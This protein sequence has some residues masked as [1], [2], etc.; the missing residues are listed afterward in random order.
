MRL[1]PAE[2]RM[3]IEELLSL[4]IFSKMNDVLKSRM[5][6]SKNEKYTLDN[7]ID[8]TE[9]KI[10][11]RKKYI[12]Q[13]EADSSTR[14]QEIQDEIETLVETIQEDRATVEEIQS[15]KQKLLAKLEKRTDLKKVQREL[16]KF[17]YEFDNKRKRLKKKVKFLEEN[18]TCPT[19]TQDIGQDFKHEKL[20]DYNNSLAEV[21]NDTKKLVAQLEKVNQKLEGFEDTISTLQKLEVREGNILNRI[22]ENEKTIYR[23]NKKKDGQATGNVYEEQAELDKLKRELE[24]HRYTRSEI[25]TILNYYQSIGTMLKDTGIKS[26]IVQK[27]LPIFN[28][29]IN[30]YLTKFDF[31]VKFE[32]DDTFSETILSRHKDKFSYASFSEGQKLR[33]DLAILLTWREIAKMKNAMSTNL[34][35]MDEIFDSSLDQSG[36]DA[37][38]DLIP[39]MEHA[40]IF[41]ISHTPAKLYDKFKNIIEVELDGNFSVLK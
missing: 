22:T 21:E 35:I 13:L 24:S 29:L 39:K 23:L 10:D 19:C 1:R 15:K 16:D 40:N 20:D 6:N 28:A 32:L 33:I 4:T 31:F 26:V 12:K 17:E 41:V 7:N 3:L 27:Y 9:D 25:N 36:V 5:S 11:L 2:R 38:I 34:L 30:Q 18:D 8:L 37:F 14:I